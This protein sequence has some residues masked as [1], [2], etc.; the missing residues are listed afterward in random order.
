MEEYISNLWNTNFMPH[1]HCYFWEP[2]IMWSHAISDGII[3]L[4]YFF[5]PI[6]LVRIVRARKDDEFSYMWLLVLFAIFIL[7]CGA[8]HIMDVI[9]IW[10]PFYRIDSALRIITAIASIGT[11]LMLFKYTPHLVMVP[12]NRKWKEMNQQLTTL[13]ESLEEKVKQRTAELESLAERYRFMAN[14]IPQ[15]VWTSDG[16]GTTNFLNSRWYEYT[17]MEKDTLGNQTDFVHPDDLPS[18]QNGLAEAVKH[19]KLFEKKLRIKGK[20]NKYRWHLSRSLPM[21]GESGEVIKWFGSS[22]DIHD[23]VI[24]NQK[25]T[26]AN[27]ELDSFVYTASHDL[28]APIHN[29]EGLLYMRQKK[30]PTTEPEAQKIDDMMARSIER[31]RIVIT[32]LADID[33]VMRDEQE[34]AQ[35]VS[36]PELLEEFKLNHLVTIQ[37]AGAQITAELESPEVCCLSRKHMRSLLDNLLSNALHYRNPDVKPEIKVNLKVD[38][39]R[40]ILSVEDN[41]LGIPESQ[42][43][44]VFEMFR[45]YHT[46]VQGTGAGLYIVKKIV[47]KAEGTIKLESTEDQGTR[48]V[49][50]LPKRA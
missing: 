17:G 41:G 29:L 34:Q 40:Y 15:I 21:F 32:D 23:Q 11:A 25:L 26:R 1:G 36:I 39:K 46:H 35:W 48:F 16:D 30:F 4:A 5:I 43:Q 22:T 2:G 8:T 50:K 6:S 18:V 19:S 28:K 47:E 49:I 20:D 31:L 14:S 45:R 3:A 33:R 13:N 12:S 24:Q 9:N 7:G 44:K 10:E 42:Q 27:E 38:K 37:Q